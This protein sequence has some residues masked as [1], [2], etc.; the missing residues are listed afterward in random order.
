MNKQEQEEFKRLQKQNSSLRKDMA[1]IVKDL[2]PKE[3]KKLFDV[4]Y[5]I[6]NNEIE[7][8]SYCNI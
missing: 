8:E 2:K 4:V 7:Q 1:L 5:N 3:Q 6:I